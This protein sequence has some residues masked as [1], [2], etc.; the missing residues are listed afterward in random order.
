VK[1][2]A[3]VVSPFSPAGQSQISNRPG[4]DGTVAYATVELT[5]E[6]S[7]EDANAVGDQIRSLAPHV[8][9]VTTL[10]GGQVFAGFKPPSSELLGLSFAIVVL[11]LS[12]GSVLAMGLPIGVALAGIGVGSVAVGLLSHVVTVPDF[13]TTLGVMIG[14]GVGI[15]YAL[16]I[17]TR[18]REQLHAGHDVGE[19][20]TIAI[21]T[22]GR[23][24]SFAG[25]TVVI[26]LL[27]ML[28]MGIG[29]VSGLAIGAATVVFVTMIAS[30]TL[31]PALLGFAGPRIEITRWRGLLGAG[32]VSIA[33][34][35]LGL[36]VQPMIIGLPLAVIVLL[37]SFAVAPL[38]QPVRRRPPKPLRDTA[39]YRWSRFVQRNPW[40]AVLV[41]GGILAVLALP[42]FGLR[43]GSADEG[44]APKD[45]DTRQAYDLLADGFGPGFNGPLLLVT[46]V[47][48]GTPAAT[49]E[50]LGEAIAA[51]PGVDQVS[52]V[53]TND[54]ANPT[55]AMWQVI[56]TTSPQDARTTDLVHRLRETVIPPAESG[57]ELR[58]A[59]TGATAIQVDFATYLGARLPLFFGAV[60]GLSFLLLLVVFRSILVP[61]KAVVM[62]LLSIG[63]AFGVVV[64]VFQWGWGASI[65]GFG[66][67]PIEAFLP[68]MLFAIVF[69][70]SMDY[71][72]FLLS[73]VKE[74]WDRTGDASNSVADGLAATA[75]VI[76]AAAA[77]MVV[78][79]G[80]F[81]L[82]SDRTIKLFGSGLAI[83]VLIDASIVRMLL[84]PATM[85]L[86]GTRNWWLPKWL[87][88]LLPTIQIEGSA[89]IDDELF[90]DEELRTP[91][92]VP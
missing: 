35:G 33:L 88:R 55:A 61:L 44:N 72:V 39:A 31:L 89:P 57:S 67:A 43:L 40:P 13:A 1:G 56:P 32:L 60:L 15:D 7:M 42:V 21:D 6:V 16:F 90:D 3:R 48:P 23:A 37:A 87:D 84:V 80:S 28:L 8:K 81:L 77:I 69:G 10:L 86:L 27:G 24:V 11:V 64:A 53:R 63:A 29:F 38:R 74:E 12:F 54:P 78:V 65:L 5:S 20:I 17:V 18:F 79:F 66:G 62:N 51:A 68:M 26:S 71:E 2:V 22:A 70:L 34:L 30:L 45:T 85:E 59:V 14:L 52:P 50:R 4:H 25:I 49:L 9:G 58:V 73:R 91:E 76:T 92:L 82:E 46:E 47:A 19:S 75:R 41:G 83:A 36:K